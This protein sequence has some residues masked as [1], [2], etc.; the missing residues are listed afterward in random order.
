MK[1]IKI[2]MKA[3][4]GQKLFIDSG[5]AFLEVSLMNT[6]KLITSIIFIVKQ[7]Y[8]LSMNI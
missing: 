3:I 4:S 1:Q 5:K 2:K 7:T 8:N 6:L